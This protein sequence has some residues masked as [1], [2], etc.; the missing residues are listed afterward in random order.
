MLINKR[1][2]VGLKHYNDCK[3]FIQYLSDMEDIYENIEEYNPN[4]ECKISI[5]CNMITDLLSNRKLK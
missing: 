1:E 4:K 5:I 3:A 2:G